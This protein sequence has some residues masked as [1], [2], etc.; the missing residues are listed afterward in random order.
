MKIL[1]KNVII[2]IS[3]LMT[4]LFVFS[5]YSYA[6]SDNE[7]DSFN[8]APKKYFNVASNKFSDVKIT[9]KDSNGI[10]SVELYSV[11]SNGKNAKKIKFSS[12]NTKN[13]KNHIY[14]LSHKNLLKGKTKYFYIKIK[15]RNGYIQN[16]G[17]KV[18]AKTKTVNNKVIKYYGIDD[19]PRVEKWSVNGN[20]VSF[21]S[22]DKGGSKYVKIQDVNNSNKQIYKFENLAKG[23]AKVTIDINKFKAKNDQYKIKIITEDTHKQQATRTVSFKLG[24]TKILFVG[25][26]KTY[27]NDVPGKFKKLVEAGG[28]RVSVTSA[29]KGGKTLEYLASNYK[30]TINK[31]YDI[32]IIQEHTNPYKGDYNAF[33]SGAKSV[34]A[35]VKSKNPNVKLFV[36]QTWVLKDSSTS[37]RKT[38]YKNAENVAKNIGASLIY[39]GK[40]IYKLSASTA[41]SDDRHQTNEGAYLTACCVYNALFNK[42]PVGLNYNAGLSSSTAKKLQKIA[43]DVYNAEKK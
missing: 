17:F 22:R 9:I 34:S 25:N 40:A 3:V 35:M 10:A 27:V 23:D 28:K 31:A 19:A 13:S 7:F 41:F 8:D 18:C 12:S 43:N 1:Y 4:F 39:D 16:S 11:D 36:R 14:V 6:S 2:I 24:T 5:N 20:K 38:A 15:D 21:V 29:T 37:V 32:V 42:S 30:N 33:L 26:S